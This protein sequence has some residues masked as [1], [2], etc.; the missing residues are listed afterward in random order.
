MDMAKKQKE[1]EQ[2]ILLDELVVSYRERVL[3]ME[4]GKAKTFAYGG[5]ALSV[6]L[7]SISS[8]LYYFHILGSWVP[9]LIGSPAGILL[10]LIGLGSLY[11]TKIGSWGIWRFREK[12]S[13]SQR[14]RRILIWFA[15]YALIFI[16]FGPFIPYGVGGAVLICLTLTAVVTARRSPEEYQLAVQG[17]PDPRDVAAA[18][19]ADEYAEQPTVADTSEDDGTVGGRLN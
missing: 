12:Y 19:A 7:I 13:Y 5:I 8:A 10:F 18:E 11:R 1:P 14:V 4:S 17:L 3:Q 15:I 9:A 6:V 2:P 16:P